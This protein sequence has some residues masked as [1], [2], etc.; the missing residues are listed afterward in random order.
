MSDYS[1]QDAELVVVGGGLAGMI[2][3]V[4]ARELGMRAT[5]AT[6]SEPGHAGNTPKAGGGFAVALG[7]DDSP[8]LHARDTLAGG[9][10]A[11]QPQLIQKMAVEAPRAV[12]MLEKAGVR[13]VRSPD[14]SPELLRVP[15]HSARRGIRCQGGGAGALMEVLVPLLRKS[16]IVLERTAV[17]DILVENR[18]V[19]G[20]LARREGSDELLWLRSPRVILATGGLGAMYPLTT[21]SPEVRGEGYAM[22][23]EAGAELV[24]MEYM[25]FTPTSLAYPPALR[26][27]STGGMLLAEGGRLYNARGERFMHRVD[28]DRAEA[29]TRDIV[30]RAILREVL[31]GRGS[32]AGGVY[33][34]LSGIPEEFLRANAGHFLNLLSSHGIDAGRERLQIAP[35]AHFTC[36]G[37]LIDE[38][39]ATCVAG[40]LAAGE[41]AGG[42]HG[43]NRLSSNALTE[44]LV[45]G[46]I[47]AETASGMESRR[48]GLRPAGIAQRRYIEA[49]EPDLSPIHDVMLRCAGLEREKES[50][51]SG[52]RFIEEHRQ[53]ITT[54]EDMSTPLLSRM[55]VTAQAVLEAALL[56]EETRGAHCRL[57]FPDELP[58][59]SY[60]SVRIRPGTDGR[61]SAARHYGDPGENALSSEIS[62]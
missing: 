52:L 53:K 2:A 20:V 29:S 17:L 54:T 14:G 45:F 23:L 47:A 4:R 42:I 59:R 41:A 61:P 18:T 38:H 33:L 31:E 58:P 24:D 5:L 11:G 35:A 39:A 48:I 46:L 22:A 12:A 10:H 1:I 19:C 57:D 7:P 6:L 32:P 25:Q 15:G 49:Q 13:F 43:A 34:D 8:E 50:I 56:R 36:G 3:A 27:V 16:A 28:P 21:N 30:A 9:L 51:E 37:V 55:L 26:G 60:Y 62:S 40:L 44:A